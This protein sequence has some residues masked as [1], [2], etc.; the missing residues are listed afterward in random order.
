MWAAVNQGGALE[1]GIQPSI[2]QVYGC[3]CWVRERTARTLAGDSFYASGLIELW[4][5]EETGNYKLLDTRL[6]IETEKVALSQ[7]EK[8]SV[9]KVLVFDLSFFFFFCYLNYVI[10]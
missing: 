1:V 8:N 3:A 7:V 4:R 10:I 9:L 5:F 2:D 6:A